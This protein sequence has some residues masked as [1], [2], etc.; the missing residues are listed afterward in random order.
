VKRLFFTLL[1][2][3]ILLNFSFSQ[4]TEKINKAIAEGD[5][6]TLFTFINSVGEKDQR[7]VTNANQT[8]R[9]Y[10]TIDAATVKYRTNKMESRVRTVGK[11]LMENVFLDPEKYLPAVVT[12]LVTGVSDQFL[13]VKAIHDWICDN[14]VYDTETAFERAN[15]RQDYISV[16]RTKLAVCAGYANLFNQMCELASIE[17]TG[18]TGYS[19]GFGYT[20]KIGSSPDHDWNAVKINNKWYLVDV[21]WDAGFIDQKTF[22]RKYSTSYLF[23]DSRSFLYSH[24]PF[25]GKYQFHAPSLTKE[26]FVNEPFIG[27]VF[28]RYQLSFKDE[29]PSYDNLVDREGLFVNING[30]NNVLLNS[31]VRTLQKNNIDGASWQS[32]SGNTF[33]FVYDVPDTQNYKGYVFARFNNDRR[34]HERIEISSFEGKIIPSLDSLLQTKKITEREKELFINS[35]FKVLGNGYY[36]FI[37]DQFDIPRN[38]AVVKIHPLVGLSLELLEPVLDFN[39]KAKSGYAGFKNYYAKRFPETFT[40]FIRA[41][42]TKLVSPINGL[43]NANTMEKFIIESRDYVRFA[44]IVDDR[45]TF[46]D[47]KPNGSFELMFE[48]TSDLNEVQIY[49]TK[50]NRNYESLLRYNVN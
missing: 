46:F 41:S 11:E 4:D 13:K 25:I 5:C 39:I 17:S 33:S 35:Y 29:L 44:I 20:G 28:F 42:N 40:A 3:S 23:L 47:K 22:V 26:Q 34:I 43:L 49:G 6:E 18:I 48:I 50:N 32:K 14:I 36:Y 10:T 15:R 21:T 19:K 38:N 37:D 2:F 31:A 45:F 1:L 30:S 16:L 24:L 7:L 9:K 27:G 12:K 8:I